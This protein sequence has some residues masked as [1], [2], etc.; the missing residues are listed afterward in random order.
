M[1]SKT[2]LSLLLIAGTIFIILSL[3]SSFS[4]RKQI[5]NAESKN[6]LLIDFFLQQGKDS[7]Y[8]NLSFSRIVIK[9]AMKLAP[10]SLSFYE[11][12]NSYVL[13]YSI[14]NQYDSANILVRKTINYCKRQK[15]S[16]P[17]YEL[18]ATS[19]NIIGF[20][21]L[22]MSNPDS[23]ISYYKK[24]L[25]QYRLAN[26]P[27][28]I[29]DMYINLADASIK[30]GDYATCTF[31]YRKALLISDS[32]HL[33]NKIGYHIY[34]GLG[35]VY[36]ELRDFELSDSYFNLA[37]RFYKDMTLADKFTFCNNRGNYYYYK[38]EYIKALPWFKKA[39]NLASKGD[40]QFYINL[41][42]L[43]LGDIYLNLN[44]PDSVLFY[45]DKSQVYFSTI[46]NKT[47]LYYIAT[48]RAGLA[49]K[50][51]NM[52]FA[53][54]VLEETKD[55][56]NIEFNVLSIRNK[57]LQEYC[58]QTEHYKLAYYF[59]SRNIAINDSIRNDIAKKRI[60]ELDLRY[61]QD[62]TLINKKLLIEK[63]T[64]QMSYL[65]L[66]SFIWI[67]ISLVVIIISVFIYFHMKRKKDLQWMKYM[68]QVT[69]LRMENI[70]NRISPHFIFN[71]LNNEINS[72]EENK[73][74][75]LYTL[76]KLLRKNIEIT[77]HMSISLFEELDFVKSYIELEC[78]NMGDNF[79]LD[80]KVDNQICLDKTFIL[81]MFIQIP[82][83]NAIKHAL[84]PKE[85]NKILCILVAKEKDGV[86][87]LVRDNGAGYFPQQTSQTKGTGTGLKVLYQTVQLLNAKNANKIIFIIQNIEKEEIICG[88]EVSIHIPNNYKFE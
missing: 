38:E 1:R 71:V 59:Q 18:L 41:C 19:N 4:C 39:Q 25:M 40:Y 45:I 23:A 74:K 37:E 76:V 7:M 43:N 36:M 24:A 48:I 87:I 22:Q 32:L 54:K 86:N 33:T 44:K 42:N 70:R 28:R 15:L 26:K 85:G 17:I 6:N 56:S 61:K 9:K 8:Q 55:S 79:H 53:R 34:L 52:Q 78:R 51:N 11:A 83:E 49:L 81:P 72:L 16:P 35:Q 2:K 68:D 57:Y 47:A 10:D 67:L 50:Q 13:T 84:N 80:W 88:T 60:A 27:D 75:N 21:Y 63:Q 69:K 29:P 62:T 20:Y 65:K 12:Y 73:R 58:A 64:S 30:K 66:T 77:E 82:V 14:I 3:F 5:N 31:Y 46:K